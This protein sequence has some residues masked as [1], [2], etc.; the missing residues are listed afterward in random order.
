MTIRYIGEQ[1]V[2]RKKTPAPPSASTAV[3]G[4]EE[5]LGELETLVE[6][7]ERGDLSLEESLKAF[8]RGVILARTCQQALTKA[9]QKVSTLTSPATD[10]NKDNAISSQSD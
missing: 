5:A 9:E 6:T 10:N 8:E 4:F 7:L 1:R 3:P 2:T